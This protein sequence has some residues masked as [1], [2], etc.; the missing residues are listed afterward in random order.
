MTTEDL[1]T[2][3]PIG[4]DEV[5]LLGTVLTVWAHPDDETYLAGGL[6]AALSDAGQPAVCVT[7]TRGEAADPQATPGE[8]AALGRTRTQELHRALAGLGVAEHHWLDLPDGRCAEVDPAVPGA[9]LRAVLDD[10]CPDTVVTFGP[11]GVTGHPDHRAVA[12]WV[13]EALAGWSGTATLLH[14]VLLS[15][16]VGRDRALDEDFGVYELGRPRECSRAEV[17]VHLD[18]AGP[19]LDRK[20][21]ALTAQASQTAGLLAAVG[22]D[23]FREWVRFETLAAPLE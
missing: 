8:R 1:P 12:R 23:R 21:A 10:V 3:I 13:V 6:L 18:L 11:D 17:S 9:C 22:A 5:A 14:P 20:V 16:N 19:L 4:A 7:A 2:S 15:E